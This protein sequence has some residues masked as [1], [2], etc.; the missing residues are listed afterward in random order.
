MIPIKRIHVGQSLRDWR[1]R[2]AEILPGQ[3]PPDRNS[4]AFHQGVPGNSGFAVGFN[5]DA[6]G[7]ARVACAAS[8]PFWE[9]PAGS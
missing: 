9:G 5:G 7:A 1:F 8:H 3:N 6:A 2:R 4:G